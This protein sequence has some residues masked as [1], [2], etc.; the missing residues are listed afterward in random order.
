MEPVASRLLQSSPPRS[1]SGANTFYAVTWFSSGRVGRLGA[2]KISLNV[3]CRH[4]NADCLTTCTLP[5]VNMHSGYRQHKSKTQNLNKEYDDNYDHFAEQTP[6]HIYFIEKLHYWK[7]IAQM[8]VTQWRRQLWGTEAR[9]PWTSNDFS[10]SSLWSKSESQL[11]C[12]C[13]IGWCRCQQVTALSISTALVTK[14]LVIQQLLHPAL[15]FAVSA[16][17]LF[18]AVPLFATNAGDA[19]A[20]TENITTQASCNTPCPEITEPLKILQYHE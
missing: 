7:P 10:F 3:W 8:T 11:L 6:S 19:T 18:L 9:A 4:L 13:E 15:K 2:L 16:M 12:I 17:T 14:L 1:G 20:V 5:A